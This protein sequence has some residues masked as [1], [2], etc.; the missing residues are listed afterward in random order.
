LSQTNLFRILTLLIFVVFSK[1]QALAS[2]FTDKP[3]TISINKTSFPYH[4]IDEQGEVAG[5]MPDLWRLWAEKQAVN[6]KFVA[7]HWKDTLAKVE[8]GELDIHAGLSVTE[9]RKERFAY[10]DAFFSHDSHFFIHRDFSNLSTIEQLKPY[11][12]GVVAGSSYFTNLRRLH[13]KLKLRLY[14]TRHDLY[15]AALNNEVMVFAGLEKL[16]KNYKHYQTLVNKYPPYKKLRFHQGKYASAVAKNNNDLLRFIKQGFNKVSLDEKSAIERKWLGKD[17]TSNALLLTFFTNFPPYMAVSSTG[18]AQGLFID[19]WRLWAEKSG[20]NV[21]FLA[22]PTSKA[23]ELIDNG[24]AD[25]HI[26]FPANSLKENSP[27]SAVTKVYGVTSGVFVSNRLTNIYNLD[28]LNGKRLALFETAPYR[29]MIEENY[30][31]IQ[32]HLFKDSFQMLNAAEIGNI[33]AI[34]GSIENISASLIQ[35]NLQSSFYRVSNISFQSKVFSLVK[36]GNKQLANIIQEGF[37]NIPIEDLIRLEE[38]WL[39]NNDNGFYR[40]LAEKITLTEKE[41][42]WLSQH[43]TVDVG[44]LKQWAPMEFVNDK[45]DLTGINPDILSLVAKRS[46]LSFNFIVFD[47]WNALYQALLEKRISLLASTSITEERKNDVLF[48]QPYWNMPWVIIHQRKLGI[49][50]DLSDFYGKKLAVIKGYSLASRIRRE[51]PLISLQLVD[52]HEHALLAVQQGS[53][54]GFIVSIA[55]ASELIK[56]ES[57]VTLMMSVV[58]ELEVEQSHIAIRKDWNNLRS[59]ID[60]TLLTI[61]ESEKQ[62]IYDRWFGVNIKTGLNKDVVLRVSAQIGAAILLILI[63]IVVWN[64]RLYREIKTRKQLEEKMKHMATHDELTGLANRVLLK[65]RLSNAINFHKRQ[66]LEIAILFIDLDGFK[67]VND[68]HGHDVGDELLQQVAKTLE[69]CVRQSD[70]VVRFGGDEFVLLLTGLHHKNE[71]AFIADK[72]L[73]L[74]QQPFQLSADT[75]YIGCSIGIAMYPDDGTSDNDLIK[76]ADTLMYQVKANGKNHYIFS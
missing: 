19:I 25:I 69:S 24:D 58:E 16:S 74:M 72:V 59:I 50:L 27:F 40:Q 61:T 17:K 31:E 67:T 52:D 22:L 36:A 73:K 38:S 44:M 43:E 13:P 42:H 12:I 48:T 18:K 64:R 10:T 46:G 54:D 56:R 47:N 23:L 35:A 70:T 33:D 21:E 76:V 15:D 6:I 45:N 8:N 4:Y 65:D 28:D 68:S 11:T 1:T 14:E 39:T 34:A 9:S 41:R 5:I 37:D 7:S 3:L 53:V 30:P 62:K 2:S 49:Q 55:S 66:K 32:I 60:K 26:G 75:V 29:K 71:A 57:L 20:N 51:H 63:V